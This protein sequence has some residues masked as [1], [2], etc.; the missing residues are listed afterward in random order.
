M[1]SMLWHCFWHDPKMPL[2]QTPGKLWAE[3]LPLGKGWHAL[4]C[5][6]L[7][8]QSMLL[9]AKRALALLWHDPKALT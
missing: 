9:F 1:Q 7:P 6:S 2:P 5:L 8:L 4:P 3:T